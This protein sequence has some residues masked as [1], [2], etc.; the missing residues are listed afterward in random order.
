[1]LPAIDLNDNVR[2]DTRKVDD[3][4]SNRKLPPEFKPAEAAIP[5]AQPQFSFSVGLIAPK[6]AR[7]LTGNAHSPS[8]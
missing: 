5:Q 4:F 8:P 2:I 7:D 3:I 1:M 6:L